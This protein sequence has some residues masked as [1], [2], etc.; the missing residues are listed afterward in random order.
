ML[1]GNRRWKMTAI[2]DGVR[3][4]VYYTDEGKAA[5]EYMYTNRADPKFPSLRVTDMLWVAILE[6]LSGE[7]STAD[8]VQAKTL[9]YA[10]HR[11]G[12][13]LAALRGEGKIDLVPLGTLCP[14]DALEGRSAKEPVYCVTVAGELWL[15]THLDRLVQSP[16]QALAHRIDAELT[17]FS[18]TQLAQLKGFLAGVLRHSHSRLQEEVLGQYGIELTT[19]TL[20]ELAAIAEMEKTL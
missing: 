7:V 4:T 1:T 10:P 15:D 9:R 13:A 11:I 6:L 3:R 20:D 16:A 5:N 19:E 18:L 17:Q 14:D 8:E 2:I 12:Q